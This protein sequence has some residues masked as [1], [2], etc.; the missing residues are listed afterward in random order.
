MPVRNKR[1]SPILYY[2]VFLVTALSVLTVNNSQAE[3]TCICVNGLNRPLCASVTD[4]KPLCP[5]KFCPRQPP[6]TP[7]LEQSR[8]PPAGT[9]ICSD[10]YIYNQYTQRYEWR[11]FCR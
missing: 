3:C 1:K 4:R 6:V 5:P 8:T 11:Q 10:K 7:P 2:F 9:Q